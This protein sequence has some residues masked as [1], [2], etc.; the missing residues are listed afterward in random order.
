MS[1][2]FGDHAKIEQQPITGKTWKLDAYL[3]I[4]LL[5][6]NTLQKPHF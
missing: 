3:Q 6:K 1:R 4:I 2:I 5:I